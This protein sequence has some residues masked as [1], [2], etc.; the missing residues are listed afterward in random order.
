[1]RPLASIALMAAVGLLA[2]QAGAHQHAQHAQH[3]P[4]HPAPGAPA[5]RHATDAVLRGNMLGIRKSVDA[6]AHYEHGHVGPEHA[7]IL[8]GNVEGH[9]RDTIARCALPPD[10]DAALHAIIVPLLRHAA[11][12]KADPANHA[13]I[14]GMRHALEQ[15]AREFDDPGFAAR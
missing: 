2:P 15:Y 6:L 14:A 8:A 3:A 13:P 11:A 5:Q 1:M 4:A 7:R 10:A 12:L 9:V